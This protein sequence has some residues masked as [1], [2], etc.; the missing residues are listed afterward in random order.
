MRVYFLTL[1]IDN[2]PEF[3]K[4]Q[5][6]TREALRASRRRCLIW[7]GTRKKLMLSFFRHTKCSA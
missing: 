7:N 2:L 4:R 1:R 6:K 5:H 3:E